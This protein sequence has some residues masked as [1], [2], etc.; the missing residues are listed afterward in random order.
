MFQEFIGVLF[1]GNCS[2]FL[3]NATIENHVSKYSV[4]GPEFAKKVQKIFYVDNL[5]TGINSVKE[6]VELVEKIQVRSSEAQ[7]NRRKFRSNSKELRTYFVTLESVVN[8][9]VYKEV[10]DSNINNKQ[11]IY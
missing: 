10:V 8:N 7:F 6:G 5:N 9:T 1:G 4:L 3:L 2:Q 11:K